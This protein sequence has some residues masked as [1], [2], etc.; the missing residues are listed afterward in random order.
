M[1]KTVR[2]ALPLTISRIRMTGAW[3]QEV[4]RRLELPENASKVVVVEFDATG[5]DVLVSIEDQ[6][7]GFDPT[8]YLGQ[9]L[10]QGNRVQ[11]RGILKAQTMAFKSINFDKGGSR[12]V[13]TF[14]RDKD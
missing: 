7:A 9:G 2:R 3:W 10:D 4:A 11:G 6:G 1:V 12:V 5:D 14:V 13:A 8:R